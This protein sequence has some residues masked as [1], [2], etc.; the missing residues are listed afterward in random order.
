MRHRPATL[1]RLRS[2][3]D[4]RGRNSWAIGDTLVALYGPP[5]PAI[6]HDGSRAR[7]EALADTLGVSVSWLTACRATSAA[8][9][10]KERRPTV[11]WSVPRH[12]A[13]RADRLALLDAFCGTCSRAH[14]TPSR[15]RLVCWLDHHDRN[16]VGQGRPRQD[17]VDKIIR[18]A[19]RLDHDSLARL[20]ER[21]SAAL[22]V[23]PAA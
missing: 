3:L 2:L 15:A 1:H 23:A 12:L 8:W 16:P 22:A 4:E 19:L 11:A 21:L 13:A 20:V 17:P 7:L 6:A 9:P 18:E 10:P 14:V 5:G